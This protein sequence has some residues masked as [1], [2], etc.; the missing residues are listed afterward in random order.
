[1]YLNEEKTLHKLK[2][3][4]IPTEKTIDFHERILKWLK[5]LSQRW[6]LMVK[7]TYQ[8]WITGFFLAL[9]LGK[10]L[11][12][13]DSRKGITIPCGKNTHKTKKQHYSFL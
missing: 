8:N 5:N 9:K 12:K 10:K 6:P 1:M 7:E 3:Y 13:K 2:N 11:G 4:P